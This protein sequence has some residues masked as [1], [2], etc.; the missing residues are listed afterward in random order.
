MTWYLVR[1]IVT[2]RDTG[3]QKG[4]AFIEYY[5][6]QTAQ[7]AIRNL[8]GY[9]LNGRKVIVKFAEKDHDSTA[10]PGRGAILLL[11][12][13]KPPV[14]MQLT[15]ILRSILKHSANSYE[16]SLKCTDCALC[17]WTES[18]QQGQ[19][20]AKGMHYPTTPSIHPGGT[21]TLVRITSVAL[22]C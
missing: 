3:R 14:I 2:D 7:S 21:I 13:C 22:A 4:F 10:R 5:D 20:E 15:I 19:H 1:R 18:W 12:P 9:D 6:W 8:D 17:R 16:A 11:N